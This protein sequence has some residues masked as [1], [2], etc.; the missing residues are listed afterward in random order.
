MR[1]VRA[2]LRVAGIAGII[3]GLMDPGCTQARRPVLDVE[4]MPGVP[5]AD[6]RVARLAAS[7]PWA[8]VR[9]ADESGA[10]GGRR[11]SARVVLGD[12]AAVL[13]SLRDRGAALALRAAGE[14]LSIVSVR[15]PVQAAVGARVDVT[16][17][18]TDLPRRHGRVRVRL[19]DGAT[20]TAVAVAESGDADPLRPAV[21]IEVPWVPARPGQVRLRAVAEWMGDGQVR[22]SSPADVDVHVRDIA[23]AV[24]VLEAR[25]S[26]GAR[27][28]RLALDGA[29]RVDVRNE[30]RVAP[31]LVTGTDLQ[32]RPATS[33]D[34]AGITLVGGV[35][36]LTTRDV[37]RLKT[38]VQDRGHTVVLILDEVPGPGP[39]TSLWPHPLGA[40]RTSGAT[41][42]ARI[43]RHAWHVREWIEPRPA[44]DA[45]PL[46]YF[47]E[48][49]PVLWGR[50]IGAGRVVMVTA[51]D[52]WRW[53]ADEDADFAGGWRALLTSLALDQ[54]SPLSLRAWL[55]HS[56][57]GQVVGLAVTAAP[58]VA[59]DAVEVTPVE[60]VEGWPASVPLWSGRP[61]QWRG[62]APWPA[63]RRIHLA[64][65]ARR[66][67]RVVAEDAAVIQVSPPA[68][69]AGWPDVVR[70]Q[71][72]SGA[73]AA[74]EAEAPRALSA[75]RAAL[76]APAGER[77][78][79]TRTWWY[80]AIVITALGLEWIL[81]RL[82]RER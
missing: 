20:G 52:A 77:R 11:A 33:R 19:L 49:T 80:A 55:G 28:A 56:G 17:M 2:A 1:A 23:L 50:P 7:S 6:A 5:D 54:P 15:A 4:V 73:L 13:A 66:G 8:D 27:F 79:V 44:T 48:G 64:A 59:V 68:L 31:G 46:A 43:G 47:D 24:D 71:A 70:H 9:R 53:R 38:A 78:Y 61:G 18:V 3:G 12:P 26:W 75:L 65:R 74:G 63:D 81:R 25:P 29:R 69:V 36:A 39:W 62:T 16:A 10:V 40:T 51:L 32:P 30:T 72:E 37:A 21:S 82:Q 58:G 22:S 67:G 14:A 42:V 34:V 60:A 45:R 35:D 41:M 57:D 76:D